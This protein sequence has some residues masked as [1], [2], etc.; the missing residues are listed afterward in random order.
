MRRRQI[1]SS[2]LFL[3][4][5]ERL[6]RLALARDDAERPVGNLLAAGE[7]FVRPGEKNRSGKTAFHHAVDVP[8]KHFRLLLLRM[9]D[10]VHAE[11]AQDKRM[12]ASEILQPQ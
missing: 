11:F 9:P 7:P 12:L 1:V 3:N 2:E 6:L 8:A 5:V 4:R 10:R